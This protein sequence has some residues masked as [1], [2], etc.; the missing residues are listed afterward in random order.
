VW[1]APTFTLWVVCRNTHLTRR[2]Y[3]H[4]DFQQMK[5]VSS[6]IV[7]VISVDR[8]APKALHQQIY[9]GY[10]VGIVGGSLRAGQRV[11]STR[12]LAVEL[13]VSR[14][15]VLNAYAQLLAEGYF[16]SRVGAGTLVCSSLPD[17]IAS[18]APVGAR[19]AGVRSGPRP[20]SLRSS[21]LPPLDHGPWHR[22]QGAFS[23]S[24]VA[25]EH[26]PFQVWTSLVTRHCRKASAKSLHYG[27]PMGS[28]DL[29][30]TICSYLRMAR[31]VRCDPQQ[32]MV[33]SGSQQALEVTAR[34]L[35]NP[36]D[37]VWTEEPGYRMARQVLMLADCRLAP[38]PVDYEGLDVA[39]GIRRCRK[40]R[41]AIV[42]PSHQYPLGVTMS[43]SRRL[44]L[45][46]WAESSGSWI[47]EDDYD[48]EFR[49]ESMPIASLQG[50][51]CNARVIYIG[52][53]SKVL[54]PSL[55]LGYIVI[56]P[57]M[58]DRFLTVRFPMDLGPSEFFQAVLADF[59][60][61][62]H[63]ARHIRR[64]RLLY[65]E[66]RSALNESIRKELG[67]AVDITGGQAGMHLSMTLPKTKSDHDI[68]LRA[69]K[70][71]LWLVPLSSSYLG[72]ASRQ[73]FILGFGSTPVE[74]I[75]IAVRKLRNVL[76]SK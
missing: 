49:Y 50:L 60:R 4:Y 44:Q 72:K 34:V 48:S 58:V 55:R 73:G 27:N 36:G 16:E 66:R 56:P 24:Q 32:I 26:F 12:M 53:F 54:F 40:A 35:L 43:A 23:V 75:P 64:M 7:P 69:A 33:V 5:R 30:E 15:P 11:P 19:S 22:R 20:V 25:F 52:T 37:W 45:L 51:D 57:D 46:E 47:I 18:L 10:R 67:F 31:G 65:G 14:I 74:K 29:R 63:F 62:G 39:E 70:Q 71:N 13:G 68:A 1:T 21:I 8:K 42:T 9:D 3:D 59:I 6:G 2:Q 41:A 61:E 28:D 17:Q 76:D 38:V